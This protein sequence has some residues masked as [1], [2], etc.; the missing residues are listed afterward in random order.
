MKETE[1]I[2]ALSKNQ[3]RFLS[4]RICGWCEQPLNRAGCGAIF[5][6]I[7]D[8]DFRAGRRGEC[9]ATYKPRKR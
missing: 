1:Q 2:A 9:L 3:R 5:G 4:H 8:E 6:G 7:C